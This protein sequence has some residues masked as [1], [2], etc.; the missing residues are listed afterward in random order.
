M[1]ESTDG[2]AFLPLDCIRN[3]GEPTSLTYIL[4]YISGSFQFTPELDSQNPVL[5]GTVIDTT[6]FVYKH[7]RGQF[8]R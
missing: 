1:N 4:N 7:A 3:F 5:L 6:L 2:I 8:T